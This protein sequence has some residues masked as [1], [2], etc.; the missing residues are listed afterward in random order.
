MVRCCYCTLKDDLYSVC[1]AI[2][3]HFV[4]CSS[5]LKKGAKKG[6]LWFCPGTFMARSTL[7]WML[8]GPAVGTLELTNRVG[9]GWSCGCQQGSC[10][11]DSSYWCNVQA[12]GSSERGFSGCTDAKCMDWVPAAVAVSDPCCK[13]EVAHADISC[14]DLESWQTAQ[15][16]C[17]DG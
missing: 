2:L 7:S 11:G 5:C 8:T 16:P 17:A 6:S 14:A 13:R 1:A 10:R 9:F 3:A 15:Q 12:E 4:L